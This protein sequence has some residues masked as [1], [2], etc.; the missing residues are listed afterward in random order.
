MSPARHAAD[1][2]YARSSVPWS[3]AFCLLSVIPIF[4]CKCLNEIR[5][6][7]NRFTYSKFLTR[8]W[9]CMWESEHGNYCDYNL[10][11]SCSRLFNLRSGG[12][13]NHYSFPECSHNTAISE[14]LFFIRWL[15]SFGL[16]PNERSATEGGGNPLHLNYVHPLLEQ[17]TRGAQNDII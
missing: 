8:C 11:N 9:F 17:E 10:I 5:N 4:K 2:R 3:W 6:S 14:M 1:C 15:S 13:S 7:L 16:K 12:L